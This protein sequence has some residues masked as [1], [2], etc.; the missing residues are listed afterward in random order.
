VDYEVDEARQHFMEGRGAARCVGREHVS[1]ILKS[2]QRF[3]D[4]VVK[5]KSVPSRRSR[6]AIADG[7]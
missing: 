4:E 5:S 3:D 7:S 6:A 2:R 1:E